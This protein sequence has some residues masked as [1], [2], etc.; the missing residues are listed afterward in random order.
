MTLNKRIQQKFLSTYK[1]EK[2]IQQKKAV[3]LMYINIIMIIA[4][5]LI[6]VVFIVI[7]QENIISAIALVTSMITLNSIGLFLLVKGKYNFSA[8]LVTIVG[9]LIIAVGFASK[10]K[11]APF[12]AFTTIIYFMFMMT[13]I[14]ALLSSTKVLISNGLLF[15][16]T[17]TIFVI[18]VFHNSKIELQ[19]QRLF[20]IAYF[21]STFAIVITTIVLITFQFITK[22][23][24]RVAEEEGNKNIANVKKIQN[25]LQQV[26][27]I[28]KDLSHSSSN[29]SEGSSHLS[30]NTQTQAASVEEITATIEEISSGIE[31]ISQNASHQTNTMQTLLS[32]M[33]KYSE[34]I[35]EMSNELK[36]MLKRTEGITK[37]VKE[38][39]EN[40]HSMDSSMGKISTSSQEMTN[41]I[42]IINDISDQINLLSLN[43]AI[44]AARA[45]DAGRGFAV[46]ADEISK[47]ADQTS[48]SVNEIG[49][50]I[51]SNDHEIQ[52][53]KDHVE[54]TVNTIS[55]ILNGVSTNFSAMKKLYS[56]MEEQI[57]ANSAINNE[58]QTAM[59]NSETIK[60]ATS[61]QQLASSEI[62]K[63]ISEINKSTQENAESADSF[64]KTA[65]EIK[66]MSKSLLEEIIKA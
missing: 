31:N 1:D 27:E 22:T 47:L 62:V 45:G 13:S 52:L 49:S 5:I 26:Q 21:E 51:S 41:I 57:A 11:T 38:G 30:E 24:I 55:K 36:G 3:A 8:N 48:S 16:F 54:N 61:E 37:F 7:L 56:G 65:E 2:I 40:L 25:I 66:K 9:S 60:N 33:E 10:Y 50:L 4:L 29:L 63:S 59:K 64:N 18:A 28:S 44:E 35:E 32:K 34:S 42:Q 12:S 15:F 39:E 23:G 17:N 53:G 19:F 58:T 43:A 6:G 14:T 20:K 46:V